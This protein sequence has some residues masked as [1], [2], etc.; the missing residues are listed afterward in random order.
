M[1]VV[2][3]A[4]EFISDVVSNHSV[5]DHIL[6]SAVLNCLCLLSWATFDLVPQ[7]GT[8]KNTQHCCSGLAIAATYLIANSSTSNSSHSGASTA[9]IGLN[10]HLFLRANLAWHRDLLNNLCR[11]NDFANFLS[12]SY[13]CNAQN[14]KD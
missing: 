14:C 9:L 8:T 11:R 7:N 4:V 3:L 13:C 1:N 5:F 2:L 12:A 10:S 6:C